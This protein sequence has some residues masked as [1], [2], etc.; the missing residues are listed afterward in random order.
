[1]NRM[2]RMAVV[3]AALAALGATMVSCGSTRSVTLRVANDAGEPVPHARIRTF[4]LNTSDVP[5][6]VTL[7]NLEEALAKKSPNATADAD[8][9]VTLTILSAHPHLVQVLP[10][11]DD[12]RFAEFEHDDSVAWEWFLMLDPVEVLPPDDERNPPGMTL[13]VVR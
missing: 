9:E 10:P 4:S 6:P 5:L 2:V 8:G 3:L 7:K 11:I 13:E 1:M 12:P